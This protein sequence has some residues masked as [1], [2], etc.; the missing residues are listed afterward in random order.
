MTAMQPRSGQPWDSLERKLPLLLGGVVAVVLLSALAVTQYEVRKSAVEATDQRL[1]RI[2]EQLGAWVGTAIAQRE[3]LV[4]DVLADPAIASLI[5]GDQAAEDAA[6]SAL[7]QLRTRNDSGLMLQVRDTAGRILLVTA[8]GD[9][10]APLD[11]GDPAAAA[12][13]VAPRDPARM[14]FGAPFASGSAGV[15]WATAPVRSGDAALGHVYQLRRVGNAAVAAQFEGI[16]GQKVDVYFA[17]GSGPWTGLAGNIQPGFVP[18]DP[19]RPFVREGPQGRHYSLARSVGDFGWTM[20]VDVPM[21]SVLAPTRAVARRIIAFGLVLLPLGGLLAWFVSRS[22]TAPLRRLGAAADA[23]AA[24]DYSRRT[25]IGRTDEIG[26]LARS[27]DSMA[28]HVEV[29]HE[30]LEERFRVAKTLAA[31]LKEANQRLQHAVEEIDAARSDAQQASRAKSE[32]L[33]TISHEIRTPINAM[34]G[35]TDLL[36]LGLGGPLSEQ[37]FDWVQR[38][39]RSGDHLTTLVNDVLDFAKIESG[40]M[41]VARD[42]SSVPA[43]VNAAVSILQGRAADKRISVS[44]DCAVEAVFLGDPHRVQQIMLNLLMNALKFT[45]EEGRIHIECERRASRSHPP[46]EDES[47]QHEWTCITVADNGTGIAADQLERIFEPFVQGQPGYTRPHGGAGLGL[48][49]SRSLARMMGGDITVESRPDHGSAFTVWLQHPGRSAAVGAHARTEG[50][51][52]SRP[53]PR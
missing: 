28:A 8:S 11:P 3:R 30:E 1:E 27:F 49:I 17:A 21:S 34:I 41:R 35:Y 43:C 50:E 5:A 39:R 22:V 13:E 14:R 7:E 20:I 9:M 12:A 42:V 40:Q 32:F 53:I 47:D 6:R 52:N 36:E 51:G 26:H 46:H 18:A 25:G 37:Q 31:E 4:L 38:I 45:A 15:F 16:I 19:E 23:I 48:A 29:T 10:M 2:S 33:A 44:V 24:G